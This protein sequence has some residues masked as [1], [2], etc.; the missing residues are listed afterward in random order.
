MQCIGSDFDTWSP[1][2]HLEEL[3][4]RTFDWALLDKERN[5]SIRANLAGQGPVEGV[6]ELLPT[7]AKKARLAVVSSSS[8]DWVDGWLDRLG[9]AEYFE[10]TICRGDAPRIKPAPDLYLQAARQMEL[11]PEECLVIEDSLNGCRA[12]KSALMTA[13]VIPNQITSV[14]DFSEADGVFQT[15]EQLGVALTKVFSVIR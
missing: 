8:H 5:Q 14:S 11:L 4:G 9:L 6:R 15:C 1:K 2:T 10:V 3:T 7:L 12:A 13:Y